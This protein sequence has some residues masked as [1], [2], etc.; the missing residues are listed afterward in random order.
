MYDDFLWFTMRHF[1]IE[2]FFSEISSCMRHTVYIVVIL[3]SRNIEHEF[4][5]RNYITIKTI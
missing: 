1:H 5:K 3:I 4:N 2:D